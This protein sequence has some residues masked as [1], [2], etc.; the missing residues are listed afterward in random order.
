VAGR[1]VELGQRLERGR[2]RGHGLE[3]LAEQR[4][5]LDLGVGAARVVREQL[6]GLHE[7]RGGGVRIGR[8]RLAGAEPRA[9]Q[10]G[11]R[12][13]RVGLGQLVCVGARE[14]VA[15]GRRREHDEARRARLE[16][17]EQRTRLLVLTAAQQRVRAPDRQHHRAAR[18]ALDGLPVLDELGEI[19]VAPELLGELRQI[20]EHDRLAGHQRDRALQDVPRLLGALGA[21]ELRLAAEQRDQLAA[22]RGRAIGLLVGRDADLGARARGPERREQHGRQLL[23]RGGDVGGRA[24]LVDDPQP[25]ARD[26]LGER[27]VRHERRGVLERGQRARQLARTGGARDLEPER[28]LAARVLRGVGEQLPHVE[29]RGRIAGAREQ[30]LELEQRALVRRREPHGLVERLA[31][32]GEIVEPAGADPRLL[33]QQIGA[34]VIVAR[35][36]DLGADQLGEVGP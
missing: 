19:L 11:A 1:V 21:R 3:R 32:L 10:R 31:C 24:V 20:G 25:L 18:I 28:D 12:G 17:R 13:G 29:Q 4:A 5:R 30:A 15:L 27:A 8:G 33:E 35:V 22:Q 9:E 26:A 16:R 2:V 23:D 14:G 36:V 34:L 7:Q 6:G